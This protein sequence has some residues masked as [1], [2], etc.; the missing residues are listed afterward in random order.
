MLKSLEQIQ[1]FSASAQVLSMH[2]SM[3][4][5]RKTGFTDFRT[6]DPASR[7]LPQLHGM[8]LTIAV[9]VVNAS[10]ASDRR[11]AVGVD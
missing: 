2:A 5:E 6:Q 7:V 3:Q 10:D 9:S 4:S 8:I 11:A 1:R